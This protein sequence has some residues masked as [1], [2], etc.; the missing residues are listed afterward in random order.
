MSFLPSVAHAEYRDGFRIQIT[1]KDGT[2]GIV[3]FGAW[4][5][6]PIFEPLRDAA[7]FR[8]FFLEGGT[9]SW[10]TGADIAPETLYEAVTRRRSNKRPQSATAPHGIRKTRETVRRG[11]D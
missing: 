10:P 11:R 9:V 6:G 8:R 2:A 7:Y 3:D 1:F 5:H 4:L